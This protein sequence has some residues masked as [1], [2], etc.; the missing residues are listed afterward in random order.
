MS[1]RV[2]VQQNP[3]AGKTL[4]GFFGLGFGRRIA[5]IIFRSRLQTSNPHRHDDVS[6]AVGLIGEGAHLSGGLFVF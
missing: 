3:G 2:Q 4:L 6:V 1:Q 5:Q